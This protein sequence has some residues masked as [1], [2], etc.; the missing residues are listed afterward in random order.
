MKQQGDCVGKAAHCEAEADAAAAAAVPD[1]SD[2]VNETVTEAAC[3]ITPWSEWSDCVPKC[4]NG[5]R[6][7]RRKYVEKR[8]K[9]KCEV[10]GNVTTKHKAFTNRRLFAC[11]CVCVFAGR[12]LS[13][14]IGADA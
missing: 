12:R 8:A 1:V 10:G 9:K 14:G 2:D 4:G 11:V 13:S 6:T 3:A 7:R 5:K